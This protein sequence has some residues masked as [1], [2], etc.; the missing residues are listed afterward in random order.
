MSG[1]TET[2]GVQSEANSGSSPFL[3]PMS[4]NAHY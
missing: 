4:F 2:T 1:A 3:R